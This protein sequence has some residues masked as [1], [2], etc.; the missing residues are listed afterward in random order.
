MRFI[1]NISQRPTTAMDVIITT[2]Q[3]AYGLEL[4]KGSERFMLNSA[5][6][7]KGRIRIRLIVVSVFI[8]VCRLFARLD[9]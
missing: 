3:K 2:I 1:L 5:V 6:I 4:E 9:S 7:I 8:T